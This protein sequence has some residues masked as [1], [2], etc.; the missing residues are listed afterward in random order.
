MFGPIWRPFVLQ[1]CKKRITVVH[2]DNARA[3]SRWALVT[4]RGFGMKA[5]AVPEIW[6]GGR[7]KCVR[8]YMC[9]YI[10]IDVYVCVY[11]YIY[12]I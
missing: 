9:I 1:A 11:I 8:K 6:G 3:V 2:E 12:I 5:L 4:Q 7:R 10:H